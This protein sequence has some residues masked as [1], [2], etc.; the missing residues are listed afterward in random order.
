LLGN[1]TLVYTKYNQEAGNKSAKQKA[2][3][4]AKSDILITKEV[5]KIIK[6][7]NFAWDQNSISQRQDEL[8]D[9]SYNLVWNY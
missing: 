9:L 1:L 2:D 6:E 8:A 5:V 3:I 7:N 4:L